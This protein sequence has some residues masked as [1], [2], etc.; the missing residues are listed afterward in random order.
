MVWP[1]KITMLSAGVKGV[2]LLIELTYYV[3]PLFDPKATDAE[4][5]PLRIPR[6]RDYLAIRLNAY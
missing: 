3:R 1:L 6:G 2:T 4:L 5:V